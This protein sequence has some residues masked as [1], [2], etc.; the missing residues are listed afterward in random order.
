MT[1]RSIFLLFSCLA[2]VAC[3][4]DLGVSDDESAPLD[5]SDDSHLVHEAGDDHV[6]TRVD[7]TDA[8][9]WIHMDLDTARQLDDDDR[10]W[11][12]RF[13]RFH[14][15]V[16][17]GSSGDA[18][19]EVAWLPDV[20]LGDVDQAPDSGW[21]TDAPDGADDDEHPD[22]AFADWYDYEVD[23][24]VLTPRPGV[25]VVRTAQADFA[26]QLLDYY[27]DAGTSGHPTFAWRQLD[28]AGK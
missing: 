6:V 27:N 1:T 25:Y 4:P 14:I 17:G 12:V 21:S 5:L 19:V 9:A 28:A 3:A 13:Q 11:D 7:A 8:E 20:E 24:H 26:V 23:G 15:A 10:E 16:N 22:Y 2:V 18:G